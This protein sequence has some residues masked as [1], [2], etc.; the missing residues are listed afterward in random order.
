MTYERR[1]YTL[2]QGPP[3]SR[4]EQL[5]LE[6]MLAKQESVYSSYSCPTTGDAA[7]ES[8]DIHGQSFMSHDHD[9]SS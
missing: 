7:T 5:E 2:A 9:G 8:W 1:R 6:T 3:T 4:D